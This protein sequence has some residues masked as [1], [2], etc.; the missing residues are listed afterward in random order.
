MH[1]ENLMSGSSLDG[2]DVKNP[3]GEDLGNIK[4]FMMDC[5]S[6]QV[7]YAVLSY[8]GITGYGR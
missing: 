8:G 1:N 2:E 4:D 5:A 6:G 3:Q 7:A